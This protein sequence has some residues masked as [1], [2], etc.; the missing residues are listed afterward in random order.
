MMW[1]AKMN[2]TI[3]SQ[4]AVRLVKINFKGVARGGV[5]DADIAAAIN[6]NSPSPNPRGSYLVIVIKK[7]IVDS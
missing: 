5:A 6:G 1:A 4:L 2:S 7:L 3:A